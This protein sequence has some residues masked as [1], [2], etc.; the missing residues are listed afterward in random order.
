MA[1]VDLGS[2]VAHLKLE[3]NDFNSNL[4][5][6]KDAID[7]TSNNFRG[8]EAAGKTFS[9]VG[10]FLTAGVTTPVVAIGSSVVKTQAQFQDAMA[11]VQ[12]LSGAS[13]KELTLLENT[14]KK[15]GSTTVFSASECADALGYMALAGWDANQSSSALP[16][17]LNLAAA[18]SMDLADASDMVTDYLSAFGM[19]AGDAGKMADMLAFAQAN[20]NTT[21]QQLG[22]AFKNCSVNAKG[23][24]QDMYTTTA[25]LGALSNQGLKGSEAGTALNA[26][27]RDM[28]NHM[29][30]GQIQIGKTNVALVDSHGNF[31]DMKDIIADV[32][33]ATDGM[34]ESE[35]QAALSTVFTADSIKAMGILLNTGADEIRGFDGEL[36][37]SK[38]TAGEMA[39]TMNNTLSGALKGLSSAWE[40]LKLNLIDTNG[41]LTTL[42]QK[43]TELVR[44]FDG[45]SP[46]VKQTITIIG[47]LVAA[48]GPVLM[49]LG[50]FMSSISAIKGGITILSSIFSAVSGVIGGIFSTVITGVYVFITD[51]LIP[52]FSALWGIM[53]AHP[54]VAIVAAI[55]ALAAGFV[56]AWNNIDGFKEFWINLWEQ[57]KQK[58]FECVDLIKSKLQEWGSNLTTFFTQTLPNAWKGMLNWFQQLPAKLK[59][60]LQVAITYVRK[61]V[62]DMI[63][64]AKEMGTKFVENV[65][66]FI[67]NL[68]E[69]IAYW[70]AFAVTKAALWVVN[71][72]K[73][74]KE[75]G[76]KFITNAINAIKQLP[77]KI[78]TWLTNTINKVTTWVTNMVNKAKQMGTKF[79]NNVVNA[80][81][82]LPGKIQTWLTNTINK[83]TTWVTNMANKAKTAGQQFLNNV[84]NMIQQ[85]PGKVQSFLTQTI[86]RVTSFVSQMASKARQAGQRFASN[87][88]SALTS[89]PG[90]MVSI[91]RNIIQGL[92]NGIGNAAGALYNKMQSIAKSALNGAKAALGIKSPS[93]KFRDEVGKWIPEGIAVGINANAD[94]VMQSMENLSNGLVTSISL[95]DINKSVNIPTFGTNMNNSS[96]EL[97]LLY[98]LKEAIKGINENEGTG[99]INITLNIDK[100]NNQ[101]SQDVRGLM[102]EMTDIVK[103]QQLVKNGKRK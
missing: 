20:S 84:S 61:W 75:M 53:L 87:I 93:R 13:G 4:N 90:Q 99:D 28:T 97:A 67:K 26:V 80:I 51:T 59:A 96:N 1:G 91:G 16:G 83:V 44:W 36:R 69:K 73:K 62:H 12:A 92:I 47:L 23:M 43:L 9:S 25:L 102:N 14:A 66:N 56:Y 70:L 98:Q 40:G 48:I 31:R 6:A 21:T 57:V 32:N 24:G 37:N 95:D 7:S 65:S 19:K 78:Q 64:K 103:G 34:S 8:V 49:I 68:P 39:N 77:G 63:E 2:I 88:K 89:L 50:K 27:F 100:F 33:K 82:Q 55:A 45:L 94:S 5:R 3:M 22:D 60:Y 71:M 76:T 79:L 72:A 42:I 81:K 15:M 86:S 54:I 46:S 35:K 52:A 29:E 11:K 74:A 17:V 38:G 85:V 101:R 30:N 58:F 10:K 41:P 18:S